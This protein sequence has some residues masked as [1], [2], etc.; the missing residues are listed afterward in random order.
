LARH[1][2]ALAMPLT[3]FRFILVQKSMFSSTCMQDLSW[4]FASN[5]TSPGRATFRAPP[6]RGAP[7]AAAARTPAERS[8][9]AAPTRQARRPMGAR[10]CCWPPGSARARLLAKPPAGADAP[11]EGLALSLEMGS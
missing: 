5:S 6:G 9:T 4:F 2:S 10:S 8:A 1:A 11:L 7:R 3:G